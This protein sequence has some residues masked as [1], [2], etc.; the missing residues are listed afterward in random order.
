MQP[1]KPS[2]SLPLLHAGKGL[3]LKPELTAA[4]LRELFHYDPLS[5]TFVRL[6]SVP[7]ASA[8]CGTASQRAGAAVGLSARKDGY[9]GIVVD[10]RRYM[11]H[12]LA[13]LYVFGEWPRQEIDHVDGQRAN[14]AIAN[15]RDVS[16]TQNNQNRQRARCDSG[17]GMLGAFP[18]G[19]GRFRA[20]IKIN[21]KATGLGRYDTASEASAAYWRAR[22]KA[23]Q[24]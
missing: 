17:S 4:R 22:E 21:G 13:W 8:A 20:S 12:R 1:E 18:D 16:R 2:A 5:G 19:R 7:G 11:A 14:N 3:T 6:R 23:R 24:V 9:I 15:L 10:G